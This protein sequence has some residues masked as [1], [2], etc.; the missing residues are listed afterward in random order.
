MTN[1]RSDSYPTDDGYMTDKIRLQYI[2][3]A[4]QDNLLPQNA[5]RMRQIV[6]LTASDNRQTPIQ[7][8]QLYSVLGQDRI[9]AIVRNF[10][11]RVFSD[12]DWFTSV[13]RKVGGLGHHVN[14]QAS[15][16]ID[17]MGGGHA[18]HGGEF[19]LNFHHTH[20]AMALMN[21]KG[22]TRWVKLMVETLDDPTLDL[23]DDPRVRP[24]INTFLTY[25]FAKYAEDFNFPNTAVFG[26][27]NPPVKRKINFLN[28]S[29]EAI[30]GLTESELE[31][32]LTD[33]GVDTRLLASKQEMVNAA[34]RL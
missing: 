30:A 16:W 32:A 21:E 18:Y 13:F 14:T 23:T 33:R 1:R 11:Q 3:A 6:S 7:F 20:N 25:F 12:E 17:V 26:E 5:H 22:A 8:W 10:Y 27:T 31:D 29:E 15:M 9:V 24:A 4:V 2:E 34:L 19:R 28:M